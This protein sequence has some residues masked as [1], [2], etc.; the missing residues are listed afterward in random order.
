MYAS[1][2]LNTQIYYYFCTQIG[3]SSNSVLP[4]IL[5]PFNRVYPFIDPRKF[6]LVFRKH[7][8]ST[9][10][11]SPFLPHSENFRRYTR[12]LR[13]TFTDATRSTATHCTAAP[14]PLSNTSPA[15]SARFSSYNVK[16]STRRRGPCPAKQRPSFPLTSLR[17]G[18]RLP[19]PPIALTSHSAERTT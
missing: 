14:V 13:K 5:Y 19:M 10:P 16:A 9:Y 2:R 8:L 7:H 4:I 11:S 15:Y 12:A 1:F 17:R 18:R 3:I 6:C